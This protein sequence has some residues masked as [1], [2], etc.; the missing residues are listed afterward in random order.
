MIYTS[1]N[2]RLSNQHT[3]INA[4]ISNI[5]EE[6]V[7]LRPAPGKWNIKENIVHLATYQPVFAERVHKILTKDSPSFERYVADNDE[8]FMMWRD[9]P[10]EILLNKIAIEREILYQLV[11]NLSEDNLMRKGIHPK[12]GNLTIIQWTEFFLLHEAHHLFTMFQL[13]NAVA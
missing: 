13:A 1:L 7:L 6:R 8:N 10:L 11:A 2:E 9:Q 4:I 5:A 12:Y 3:V